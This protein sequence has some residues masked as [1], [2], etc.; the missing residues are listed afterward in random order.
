[1]EST[2]GMLTDHK[3]QSRLIEEVIT[4]GYCVGCGVCAATKNSPFTMTLDHQ[5]TYK[6]E[7]SNHEGTI[8]VAQ[9]CP[10]FSGSKNEDE[11]GERLFGSYESIKHHKTT[12]YYLSLLSGY[13]SDETMRSQSTSGGFASWVALKL[14][15]REDVDGVV[16]VKASPHSK[17]LFEYSMSLT[18]EEVSQGATSK[19][20]P[21][22]L[23]QI[24]K[25]VKKT[26]K[27]FVFVG[28][29]C[30]IKAIRLFA[31]HDES[32]KKQVAY[33][34]GI[35]CGHLKSTWFTDAMTM[36]LGLNPDEL[37]H[38]EYRI[39]VDGE[40]S[41]EFGVQAH[42][43]DT[44]R[45]A[46]ASSLHVSDWGQGPFQLKACDYCD[47]VLAEL[48]DVTCGDAWL[49]KYESDHRGA[50]IMIVRHPVIM[51]LLKTY[52]DELTTEVCSLDEIYAT[53]AGGFRHR[54]QGLAYRLYLDQQQH[55][56]VPKKRI[57]PN[58]SHLTNQRKAIYEQRIKL[59]E[60]SFMAF[61]K[62][63]EA[64]D[65]S[66]YAAIMDPLIEAYKKL[67]QTQK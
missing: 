39:K 35:V 37:T 34:I 47:D 25:Q 62:A 33:T 21:I 54:H 32:F 31:E 59:R 11:L 40:P 7:F 20:Y 9:V 56:L 2:Y 53:Q 18:N 55:K 43:K 63:R 10:F 22:E 24:I 45:Y 52:Q 65:F 66:M 64:N 4:P 67:Y 49:P 44:S 51:Q 46:L 42:T 6:P 23:S 38:F 60:A 57:Q 12:G 8:E 5:G 1:M 36:E 61:E 16:H 41:S 29:P 26:N 58:D 30:F 15:E 27:R 28:I 19:Y 3:K 50:S 48:A 14:L 17:Q 13:V